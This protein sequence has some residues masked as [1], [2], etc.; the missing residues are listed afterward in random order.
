MEDQRQVDEQAT[1]E[2]IYRD[3]LRD[4]RAKLEAANAA[5]VEAAREYKEAEV[6]LLDAH[7]RVS[8]L[9]AEIRVHI[10]FA[11]REGVELG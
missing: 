11:R 9:E 6:Q 7:G 3:Y 8:E 2:K 4:A 5:L 1:K 10:D